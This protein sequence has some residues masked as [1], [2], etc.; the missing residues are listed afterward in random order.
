MSSEVNEQSAAV[1]VVHRLRASRMVLLG[2]FILPVGVFASPDTSV[3]SGF[4]WTQD[5]PIFLLYIATLVA[6]T[7][8]I[9]TLQLPSWRCSWA[10]VSLG[11]LL[12]ALVLWLGTYVI[13]L[14]YAVTRDEHMVLF[15]MAIFAKGHLVE[16]LAPEWRPFLKALVPDFAITAPG[17]I[18]TVSSYLPGNAILRLAL[19]RVADS[20]L[21]N[22]LLVGLSV[23]ALFDIARRLFPDDSR[24]VLVTMLLYVM[25]A[26]LL[27][28][29]MTNYAMTGHTALNLIW[30]A[31]FLRDRPWAHALAMVISVLACGLHQVVFHPLFA[32]P[33]L[34]WRL[35]QGRY[36]LF[37]AYT[38]VFVA[39]LLFWM[40]YPELALSSAG[41]GGASNGPPAFTH[42][43]LERAVAMLFDPYNQGRVFGG[44][45]NLIR[46]V[47]WQHLA[48]VPLIFAAWPSIRRGEEVALPLA[49]GILLTFL[50]CTIVMPYQG[51]G[52]GYRYFCAVM[53]NGVL[54]AGIG[55]HRWA[56]RDPS[57][58]NG[59]FVSFSILTM[60][61]AA[62]LMVTSRDFI[63]PYV[64]VDKLLN[65]ATSDMV[66]VDTEKPRAA[67]D[68]VRNQPDLSNR[69]LLLS[70]YDTTAAGLATLCSRGTIAIVTR[71][72]MQALGFAR[73]LPNESPRFERKVAA[74]LGG[75]S[76]LVSFGEAFPRS[77]PQ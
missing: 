43:S 26:Q 17:S 37:A 56:A 7:F 63:Q 45:V 10:S 54:L 61:A 34:L 15:D 65:S 5:F 52:W 16:P 71:A 48:L 4:F 75:K 12:L 35:R 76:C 9:P 68:L 2:L 28:N 18:A 77:Q 67:I 72:D 27:V 24:A 47:T 39:A 62:F 51:H 1:P 46:Y 14:N 42:S 57:C 13:M 58:A 55:Y 29:A 19:S 20:A 49:A 60:P 6:M 69:P 11:A 70:S 21:M 32:G 3:A 22:P 31:L 38:A 36:A 41:S 74:G 44:V 33:L 64:R 73:G 23:L 8:R 40:R 25:S 53:G 30:L 66:L 59:L 50:L